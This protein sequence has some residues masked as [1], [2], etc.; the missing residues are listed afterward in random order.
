MGLDCV[1]EGVE[2]KAELATLKK[3]GGVMAQGY[4]YSPPLPVSE[5]ANLIARWNTPAEAASAG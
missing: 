5:I 4:L 1:I 2:T 3:L